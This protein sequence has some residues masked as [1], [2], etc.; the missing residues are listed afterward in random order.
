MHGDDVYNATTMTDG[1][2]AK[3]F[4]VPS[5]L[6]SVRRFGVKVA[7]VLLSFLAFVVEEVVTSCLSCGALYLFEFV[8]CTAFLFS[9]LLLILLATKLN[10]MVGITCWVKLDFVYTAV[11]ALCFLLASIVFAAVNGGTSLEYTAVVF[12][13]LA[14]LAFVLDLV[15]FW[16]E[17]GFPW[18]RLG[19]EA[20]GSPTEAVPE[21]EGLNT[22]PN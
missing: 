18:K 1:R 10:S 8:S 19:Q 15:L 2:R 3:T 9:L 16:K 11:I 6:L 14:T 5:S 7:E 4:S 21:A 22:Q 20:K 13:F 12:G 17:P